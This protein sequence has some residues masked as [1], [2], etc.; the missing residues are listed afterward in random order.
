[1]VNSEVY[2][3]NIKQELTNQ[4]N[5]AKESILIAMAEFTDKGLFEILLQR[6][7]TIRV[8]LL[9]Y[10]DLTS[11]NKTEIDFNLLEKAGGHFYLISDGFASRK[12]CV[13]DGSTSITG[14][15]N[16]SYENSLNNDENIVVVKGDMELAS[17]YLQIFKT[18]IGE[19][20]QML[21]DEAI[22]RIIKRLMLIKNLIELEDTAEIIRHAD[23]IRKEDKQLITSEIIE[24]LHLKQY[25]KAI[26]SIND[27]L[28]QFYQLT[29]YVDPEIIALN[30]EIKQ[31]EYQLVAIDN[32]LTETEKIIADFNHRMYSRLGR[33]MTE[34]YRLKKEHAYIHRN[35]NEEAQ[36]KYETAKEQYERF[37]KD[38]EKEQLK[39]FFELDLVGQ[40]LLKEMYRNAAMQCHPDKFTDEIQKL[41]AT[42]LFVQLKDAYERRDIE[43]VKRILE[44][45]KNGWLNTDIPKQNN[46]GILKLKLEELQMLLQHKIELLNRIKEAELFKIIASYSNLDLYFD[47]E[48]SQ[49]QFELKKYR[50]ELGKDE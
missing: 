25:A 50:T 49:L 6:S 31:L 20:P 48:E 5:S 9:I 29:K 26:R 7:K 13:I 27:F 32:E 34:L 23:F 22:N 42:E 15:S 41:K 39:I 11:S 38:Q 46:K 37:T 4:L 36:R 19:M 18:L 28:K 43:T 45:L 12:F 30:L 35:D 14:S 8:D 40:K 16:W 1:M 17:N 33:L 44:K 10:K 3:T 21:S 24:A 47:E 2:F